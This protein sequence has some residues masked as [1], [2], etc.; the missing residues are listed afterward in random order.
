MVSQLRRRRAN[1]TTDKDGTIWQPDFSDP[2]YL[3]YWSALV[4]ERPRARYDGHPFLDSVDI[5]SVGYWGE[6]W[7]DYMPG[8]SVSKGTH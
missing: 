6:G 2:L 7:S 5:S 1:Q 4:A 3:K 8:I